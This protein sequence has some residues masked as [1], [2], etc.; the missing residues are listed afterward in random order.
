MPTE[1][2]VHSRNW[3]QFSSYK[4]SRPIRFKNRWHRRVLVKLS[5]DPAVDEIEPHDGPA[6]GGIVFRIAGS[7]G[8]HLIGLIDQAD[9]PAP[10]GATRI[11]RRD[12]V[13]RDKV[14]ACANEV[15]RYRRCPVSI[16]SQL[17]ITDHLLEAPN[18]PLAALLPFI[19]EDEPIAAVMA[20]ICRGLLRVDLSHGLSS[21][22]EVSLNPRP[23]R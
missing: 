3:P 6:S 9:G 16:K 13:L 20:L 12:M 14:Y 22:I 21:A 17:Q 15:W 10:T 19:E 5:L 4:T 8:I 1:E 11:I 18:R 2:N 23:P 7:M